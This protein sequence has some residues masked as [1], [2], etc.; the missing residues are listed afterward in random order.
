MTNKY[1]T[2]KKKKDIYVKEKKKLFVS[3]YLYHGTG[4]GAFRKI[5]EQGLIPQEGKELYLANTEEYARSYAQRKGNSFGDRILRV[6][7][8][9]DMIQDENTGLVG[10]Y[11]TSNKIEPQNIEVKIESRWIP[12][13]EYSDESINIMPVA[14]PYAYCSIAGE[15]GIELLSID[16]G[17]D[18]VINYRYTNDPTILS[19]TISEFEE[20]VA[21]DSMFMKSGFKDK[22][23]TVFYFSDFL[24]LDV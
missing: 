14:K 4:E 6:K 8:T 21:E 10:D 17:I 20:E 2:A 15:L 5:R 1:F 12:I 13:Q 16:Y 24:R 23:G 22:N 11:K 19:S 9:N 18:D 7:K 3:S